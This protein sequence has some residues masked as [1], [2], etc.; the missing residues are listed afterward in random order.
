MELSVESLSKIG[1]LMA[2]GGRFGG[3]QIVSEAYV[4]RATAVQQMNREGGYGYFFWKYR[5]GYSMNGKWKQKCY[6]LPEDG[7][8]IGY[9]AD[10]REECPLR[11]SMEKHLLGAE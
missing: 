3:Q 8:V 2:G 1:L 11:Q 10:I 9:L 5:N 6:I 7:L 4:K